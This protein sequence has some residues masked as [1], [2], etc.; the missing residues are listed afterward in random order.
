MKVV[1]VGPSLPD[2]AAIVRAM[3]AE[4][5]EI[6]PPAQRGDLRRAL[7]EGAAAIGLIDG[8]FEHVRP[9][10]HKEILLALSRGVP[11]LGAASM[12]AL[13]AVECAPFGMRGV[14]RIYEDYRSGRRID[15][16]DVALQHG[17]AELGYP[18]LSV[19][20]VTVDATLKTAL[21][22]G[23][24]S[25]DEARDWALAARAIHF[26]ERSWRRIG[27]MFVGANTKS[28]QRILAHATDPKRQ[29]ALALLHE[30]NLTQPAVFKRLPDWTL[31]LLP[32]S[33]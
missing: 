33:D 32:D 28:M 7:E 17:P 25:P 30:I 5:I 19:P 8:I 20:L 15:D 21:Q 11:V 13:R 22:A 14:G 3:G 29:D 26:K 27:D 4:D 2:A 1:F 9:V 6:R 18:P 12:G 31:H 16:G 23:A 24:I 10:W